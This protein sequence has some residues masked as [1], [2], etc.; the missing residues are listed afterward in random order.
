MQ[1]LPQKENRN[2]VNKM[3]VRKKLKTKRAN[4]DNVVTVDMTLV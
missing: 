4:I 2:N 1:Y 3:M